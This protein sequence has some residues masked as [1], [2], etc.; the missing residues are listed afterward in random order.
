MR[1]LYLQIYLAVVASVLLLVLL[2]SLVWFWAEPTGGGSLEAVASLVEQH[3]PPAGSSPNEIDAALQALSRKFHVTLTL[4]DPSGRELGSTS[5]SPLPRPRADWTDSRFLRSR[6]GGLTLALRFS[7]GRWLSVHHRQESHAFAAFLALGLSAIAVAAAAYPVVRRLTGRLERLQERVDALGEG[8]L[9][10]R[11]AVEGNDEVARLAGSFNRAA[12]RIERLIEA[13]R[14]L[15]AGASHEL[16]SPLTRMRL[17]VELMGDRAPSELKGRIEKEIADLDEL[18]G[19]LILA[20]R[21]EARQAMGPEERIDLLA[22]AVEEASRYDARVEGTPVSIPGNRSLLR[23]LVRNLLEN[24]R[25]HA[26]GSPIDV[27]VRPRNG[28]AVIQI[29]DRGPGVPVQER[30][31]IFEPFYSGSRAPLSEEKSAGLGLSLVRRIA[32]YHGGSARCLERPG[33]G[34]LFEVVISGAGPRA[35][36]EKPSARGEAETA[37]PRNR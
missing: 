5:P 8:Q 13:Q 24:A 15:L 17:A 31:R 22:L 34:S 21:I 12:E 28:A 27:D 9:G 23:R 25:Q 19:E 16:R 4:W 11:V 29:M 6:R 2:F 1:R 14:A 18:I 37:S 3:I 26:L 33:G 36:T 30:E 10:S 32:G 20:S 7:D 35:A